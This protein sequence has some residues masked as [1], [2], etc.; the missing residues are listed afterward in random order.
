MKALDISGATFGRLTAI[1]PN[2]FDEQPSR[3]HI[4]WLCQCS[5]G[6]QITV[7]LNG[8]RSGG[9]KSCGCINKSGEHRATHRMISTPEYKT[10]ARMKDRCYNKNSADYPLYGARGI[11]VS[12]D[13]RSSFES[14]YRD[15][16]PRPNNKASLD[17]IDSNGNYEK[18]NC[19]WADDYTQSRNKRNNVNLQ[20]NGESMCLTDWAKRLGISPSTLSERI[21]KW[22]LEKALT[23][24][25]GE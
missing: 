4:T 12:A 14:F 5:C 20:L 21:S 19:R 10:W 2:G 18:G 23:T 9:T 11:S 22:T 3:R 8:L 13:W 25:K 7:R 15:I 17:R 24:P 6:S 16:G 1:R